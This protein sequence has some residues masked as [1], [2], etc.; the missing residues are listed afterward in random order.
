MG[1]KQ[2]CKKKNYFKIQCLSVVVEPGYYTLTSG[3]DD[4]K[5]NNLQHTFASITFDKTT[6]YLSESKKRKGKGK[7]VVRTKESSI[8]AILLADLISKAADWASAS[9]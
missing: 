8:N 6:T 5:N 4:F 3:V 2:Q 9:E 7:V 1:A